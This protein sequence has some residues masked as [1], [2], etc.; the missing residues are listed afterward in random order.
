LYESSSSVKAEEEEE[1]ISLLISPL[2]TKIKIKIN[3]WRIRIGLLCEIGG[4]PRRRRR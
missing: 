2:T 4:R 3:P 1:A